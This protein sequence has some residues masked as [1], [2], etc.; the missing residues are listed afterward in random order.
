MACTRGRY[1]RINHRSKDLASPGIIKEYLFLAQ[2]REV[3]SNLLHI[4]G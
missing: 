3:G 1:L 2:R 4:H